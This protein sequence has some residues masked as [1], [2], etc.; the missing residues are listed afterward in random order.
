LAT[1]EHG[2]RLKRNHEMKILR[3]NIS[4]VHG[5]KAGYDKKISQFNLDLRETCEMPGNLIENTKN[6]FVRKFETR[7]QN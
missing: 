3:K 4:E 6:G 7:L 1:S 5:K 2:R